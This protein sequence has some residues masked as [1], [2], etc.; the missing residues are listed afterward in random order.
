MKL[1]APPPTRVLPGFFRVP[2]TVAASFSVLT[3]GTAVVFDLPLRDPDG[4]L[5][6]SYIRLPFLLG[7][8]ILVDVASR[9]LLQRSSS[10]NLLGLAAAEF[11]RRWS[12]P[13]LVATSVGILTFYLAYVSYRNM[14][15]FLPF[16]RDRVMDPLLQQSDRWLT[17]GSHPGDA[18]QDA[19]GTGLSAHVLSVVYVSYLYFVPLSIAAA[20]ACSRQLSRGAWYVS[21][22]S[23][24]W[25]LG[26]ASY[27]ALPSLGPI[28]VERIHYTDLPDTAV[29]NLQESLY[30]SR[31]R[32]LVDPHATDS[33]YGIAAFASLHVS[34]VFT[35]ALIAHLVRL[36]LVLRAILWVY[37]LLTA[38]AT[39]YFGWH[40]LVDVVAGAAI[41]ALAT[42]L[43][44]LA[45]PPSAHTD[46]RVEQQSRTIGLRA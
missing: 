21:A 27:Y 25:M 19:L 18:L 17:G 5:G 1:K 46:Q 12:G 35:A 28:F 13:R 4:F 24:N 37:V 33:M 30:R 15:S 41:G 42:W 26:A 22:V 20:L 8:M 34:V 31:L 43:A 2:F 44:G 32:V 23:F 29:T 6:P 3:A 39:V 38:L 14:K 16:I 10:R 11:R 45:T 40:Y 7:A 9:T 36:P